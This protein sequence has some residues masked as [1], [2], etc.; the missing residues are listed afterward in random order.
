MGWDG[1]M[2]QARFTRI[3]VVRWLGPG[4]RRDLLGL[5]E[6]VQLIDGV[7]ESPCHGIKYESTSHDPSDENFLP[8]Y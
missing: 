8:D 6:Y 3:D 4:S 7:R 2:G 5:D 1:W